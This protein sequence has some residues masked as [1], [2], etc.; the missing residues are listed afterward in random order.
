M[1]KN[2]FFIS[3]PVDTYSGYGARARDLVR[4]IIN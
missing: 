1:N 2:T 4:A 3:A